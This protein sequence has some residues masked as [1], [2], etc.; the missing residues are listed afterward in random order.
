[1]ATHHEYDDRFWRFI[2]NFR[3]ETP[4]GKAIYNRKDSASWDIT[5]PGNKAVI[6]YRIKLP[7]LPRFAHRPFLASYGGLLGDI[8]SFMYMVEQSHI[9]SSVT[10]ELPKEW[11]IATG[12]EKTADR[13][14]FIASSA[15]TLLDCPVLV[16]RLHQWTFRAGNKPHTIAYLSATSKLSFD[17]SLFISNIQKIVIQT[18]RLFGG[19]PYKN[20]TFLFEDGVNGALEHS[21]SVTI[22]APADIITNHKQDI[23]SEIAHEFS[24]TWNLMFIKPAEYT[25]LNYGPQEQSAGLWFSEGLAMFYSDLL[26]RRAGLPVEEFTRVAHLE[27][28]IKRYYADTGNMVIP[29]GK[30]SLASNA[31]PGMLGDYSASTHLQ[32]ELLGAMLDMLIR[33]ITDNQHSFDDVMRLMFKRFGGDKGFYAQD[34]ERVVADVCRDNRV[35]VFFQNYVYAGKPLDFNQYLRLI[36]LKL[37]LSYQPAVDDKGQPAPD[38]RVYTWKPQGDTV[39]HI[40]MTHPESCWVKA[41]LHTGNAVIAINNQFIKSRQDFYNTLKTIKIGDTVI[42]Q[43]NH[44]DGLQKIPVVI[45][46]YQVP[47]ANITKVNDPGIRVQNL[48]QKWEQGQ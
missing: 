44:A 45:T 43:V 9:P 19:I 35:H 7:D 12:L 3:I 32:G 8:H 15:K 34:I 23:Y 21:N 40:I 6:Y 4:N 48:Y 18:V 39:Y 28:L 13:K 27:G 30:V 22:G 26:L 24:H 11:Q 20:Y 1:M 37:E 36:G 17:T 31:P 42:V 10:F 47:V 41:G 16:G 14:T 38:T 5:I 46:G 29:P 33:N 2:R 25:E